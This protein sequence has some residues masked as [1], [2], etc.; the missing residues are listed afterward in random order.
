MTSQLPSIAPAASSRSQSSLF[1]NFDN[2]RHRS[3]SSDR[4]HNISPRDPRRDNND[5]R[6][7]AT[8]RYRTGG[9]NG[10][11]KHD[12]TATTIRPLTNQTSILSPNDN[13]LRGTGSRRSELPNSCDNT[14]Q[15]VA[16]PGADLLHL[17]S[18]RTLLNSFSRNQLSCEA[19]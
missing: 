17:E 8:A 10:G 16:S 5:S 18:T 7:I 12:R 19:D 4:A 1:G 6:R 13:Q 11:W 15:P 3:R 14:S 2:K 9:E